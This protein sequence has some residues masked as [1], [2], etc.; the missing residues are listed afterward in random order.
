LPRVKKR[1]AYIVG[2]AGHVVPTSLVSAQRSF[3]L[4]NVLD[5]YSQKGKGEEFIS[6][7]GLRATNTKLNTAFLKEYAVLIHRIIR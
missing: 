5:V 1:A 4:V 3:G 6:W 7:I 2:E